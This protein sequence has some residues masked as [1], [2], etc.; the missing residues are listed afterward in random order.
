MKVDPIDPICLCYELFYLS[1]SP[2][3][4]QSPD[5]LYTYTIRVRVMHFLQLEFRLGLYTYT[6][7]VRIIYSYKHGQINTIDQGSDVLVI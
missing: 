3:V 6:N 7:I 4:L 1:S 2:Q 5:V